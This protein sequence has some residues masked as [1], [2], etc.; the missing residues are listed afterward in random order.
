MSPAARVA[1][2][3]GH[4]ETRIAA[5]RRDVERYRRYAVEDA[6]KGEGLTF[7]IEVISQMRLWLISQ[8]V[9]E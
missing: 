6:A 4:V 9:D 3:E 5:V 1:T 8:G 7:T 2:L